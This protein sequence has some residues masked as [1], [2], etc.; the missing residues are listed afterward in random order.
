MIGDSKKR[1]VLQTKVGI[2]RNKEMKKMG[3]ERG[4]MRIDDFQ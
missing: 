1:I 2:I 4:I 3:G